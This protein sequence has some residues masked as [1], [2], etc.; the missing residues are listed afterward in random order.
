MIVHVSIPADDCRAV[1]QVLAEMMGGGTVPFPPGGSEAWSAWS[2]DAQNQIVVTPRGHYM[3]PGEREMEW[4]ASHARV[5][6]SETH[7][8]LSVERSAAEVVA[9]A[10]A[11][12][13]LARICD[14]GGFFHVVE[15]WVE[16][17]YLIEVLDPGL[18]EDYRR[19]M[20]V[21]NWLHHFG[22]AA[23]DAEP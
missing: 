23:G 5:R 4:S 12:G 8:A 9:L 19:S 16:G 17:A 21:E 22:G 13:W 1:A 2:R 11:A 20:T 10:E 14:R 3:V 18:A 6:A 7:L 15:V